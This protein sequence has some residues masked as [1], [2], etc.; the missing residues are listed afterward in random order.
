MRDG[1]YA[2]VEGVKLYGEPGVDVKGEGWYI[3]VPISYDHTLWIIDQIAPKLWEKAGAKA[4]KV[5]GM[6]GFERG[7]LA[8]MNMK[9]SSY[10]K[11]H[12][13]ASST[14]LLVTAGTRK[15]WLAEPHLYAVDKG[16]WNCMGTTMLPDC[17]NP[18]APEYDPVKC[19]WKGSEPVTLKTGEAIMFPKEWWHVVKGEPES[20]AIGIDLSEAEA[21]TVKRIQNVGKTR[22]TL[23]WTS[24]KRI[25]TIMA[26][27]GMP[28]P[29]SQPA[30]VAHILGR[31]NQSLIKINEEDDQA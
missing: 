16:G 28:L 10:T 14:L 22:G 17:H 2:R 4:K 6:D 27:K 25:F 18:A 21:C 12:K 20:I 9:T 24:A 11:V 26:E 5:K 29:A 31:S 15:I 13:D 1:A 7:S 30:L 8:F 3:Q 19:G 23:G